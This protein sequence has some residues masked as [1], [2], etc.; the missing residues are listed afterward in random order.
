MPKEIQTL[1]FAETVILWDPAQENETQYPYPPGVSK[2]KKI[3]DLIDLVEE[4]FT[5]RFDE[6]MLTIRAQMNRIIEEDDIDD[7]PKFNDYI[8]TFLIKKYQN[9]TKKAEAVIF[10]PKKPENFE[11]ARDTG[12]L[13]A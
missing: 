13:Q 1:Q 7:I 4:I 2:L 5:K 8:Y 11:R 10:P 3:D 9:C 6:E 12:P